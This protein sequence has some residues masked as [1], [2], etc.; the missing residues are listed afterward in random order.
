MLAL[1]IVAGFAIAYDATAD[2][3]TL[4][5][6]P[7]SASPSGEIHNG[8]LVWVDLVTTDTQK[9]VKFYSTVL[10][11]QAQYF[12]DENYIELNRDQ[13]SDVL[14]EED[15]AK[16]GDARWLVSTSVDDVGEAAQ[17]AVEMGGFDFQVVGVYQSDLPETR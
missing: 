8:K 15:E 11:W 1:A 14:F 17:R 10:G 16:D 12:A 5:V 9:A 7:I 13:R 3:T 4:V 6:S 2:K